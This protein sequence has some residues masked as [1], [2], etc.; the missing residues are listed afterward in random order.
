MKFY[1]IVIVLSLISYL[2]LENVQVLDIFHFVRLLVIVGMETIT[3]LL[4]SFAVVFFFPLI[5]YRFKD[6]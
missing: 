5:F 6:V 2:L 4:F 3:I 1:T